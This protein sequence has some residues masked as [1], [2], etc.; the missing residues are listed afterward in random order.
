M[1]K[2]ARPDLAAIA[3]LP[4][5]EAMRQ[6]ETIVASLERGDVSLEDS[7]KL[8]ETGEALKKR[9]DALLREAEMRIEKITL[10]ADGQPSGT[11]PLDK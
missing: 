2:D 3:V 6:L 9:C 11:V 7:I 4:F 10:G 8:Y 1:S 5:E